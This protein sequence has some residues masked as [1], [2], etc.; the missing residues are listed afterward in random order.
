MKLLIANL[1]VPLRSPLLGR[2]IHHTRITTAFDHLHLKRNNLNLF[3]STANNGLFGS[4]QL[5]E[6]RDFQLMYQ[7]TVDRSKALVNE[8]QDKNRERKLVEIFD[9]LSN[10]I[11]K[12]ADL[13]EFLKVTHPSQRFSVPAEEVSSNLSELVEQLNTNKSLY[14]ALKHVVDNGDRF[15]TDQVDDYVSRLFLHDIEQCGI[16]LDEFK[17]NQVVKLTNQIFMLSREFVQNSSQPVIL[18]KDSIDKGKLKFV[19]STYTYKRSKNIIIK[20]PYLD[21]ADDVMRERAIRRT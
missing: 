14:L 16:H 15:P 7:D 5:N 10:T 20:S 18:P 2:S 11:C 9:N 4:Y 13:C 6:P 1:L 3:K 19:P 12:A 8:A 21:D 17:R